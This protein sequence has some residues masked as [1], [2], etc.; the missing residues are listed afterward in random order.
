MRISTAFAFERATDAMAERQRRMNEAQNDLATGRRLSRLS[1]DPVSAAQ[2]ERTRAQISRI[3]VDRRMAEFGRQM[4][5]N[6]DVTVAAAS[7]KLQEAREV[8]LQAGNATQGPG[9]RSIL[10]ARLRSINEDLLAIANRRD[11]AGG[12]VFGGQGSATAPFPNGLGGSF[13]PV[14]GEQKV[15]LDRDISVSVDGRESFEGIPTGAGART[16]FQVLADASAAIGDPAATAASASQAAS[17]AIDGIDVAA[18][19]LQ[20]QR[21]R[22]GEQM[23]ELEAKES[24]DSGTELNAKA[25]LSE[26]VD[27]DL[28]EAIS[29]FNQMQTAQQAAMKTYAQIA[30]MSLFD[31]L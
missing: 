15:G 30:R 13:Q 6:A 27:I 10:A 23:R 21:T 1:E 8:L 25:R 22:I 2:A 14:A 9:E 12:F 24:L 17:G 28:A 26:L 19:R 29:E 31:Y 16:I 18:G 5:G 3:A 4:L 20:V 11:G 7:D